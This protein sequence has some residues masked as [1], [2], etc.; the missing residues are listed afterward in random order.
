[1]TM[2]RR[3]AGQTEGGG[4]DLELQKENHLRCG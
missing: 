2:I 3:E 4:S 1:M